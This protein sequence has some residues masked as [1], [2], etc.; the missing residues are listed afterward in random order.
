MDSESHAV[1]FVDGEGS[2]ITTSSM[3]SCM[4]NEMV[5]FWPLNTIK[6]RSHNQPNLHLFLALKI[7]P[8]LYNIANLQ[9]FFTHIFSMRKKVCK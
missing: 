6:Q 9:L 3:E 8:S 5:C 4:C 1:S 2:C 7:P